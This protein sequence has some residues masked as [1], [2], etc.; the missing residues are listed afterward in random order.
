MVVRLSTY[1][2]GSSQIVDCRFSP[3]LLVDGIFLKQNRLDL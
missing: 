1:L 2:G 3:E